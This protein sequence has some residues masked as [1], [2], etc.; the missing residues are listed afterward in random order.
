MTAVYLSLGSNLLDRYHL[1][2]EALNRLSQLPE[3]HLLAKSSIYETPA[4]GNTNQGDFLNMACYLETRLEP[5]EFL[6]YCQSI[7]TDLGRIRHEKWGPRPIDIDILL[8]GHQHL[9]TE[10]LQLPHPFMKERAFVLLPLLEINPELTS[11]GK[12]DFLKNYL[13]NLDKQ[14]IK[15][16]SQTDEKNF[17]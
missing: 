15:K 3:T 5:L 1:L 11:D 12:S 7:E 8:F 2:K 17:S 14:G 16:Y 4:W 13:R 9:D 10:E 6:R